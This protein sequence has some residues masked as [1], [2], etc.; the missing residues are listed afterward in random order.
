MMSHRNGEWLNTMS[1]E[2]HNGDPIKVRAKR[3]IKAGEQIYT[4]YNHC[5][6]CGN[7]LTSYGTPE[8]LRDYGFVEQFPQSWIFHGEDVAFRIDEVKTEAGEPTGEIQLVEWI[9]GDPDED[10]MDE[11]ADLLDELARNKEKYLSVRDPSVPDNE[12]SI[13]VQ[14]VDA[15][16]FAIS[17][18]IKTYKETHDFN[19]VEEGTC[20]VSADKYTDLEKKY[21]YE[22]VYWTGHECDIAAIFE[23]FDEEFE[24]LE[25]TDSQYQHI[26]WSWDPEV[27]PLRMKVVNLFGFIYYSDVLTAFVLLYSFINP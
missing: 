5:E 3:N 11:F 16:E 1:N 25:E 23:R 22:D 14:Y 6:D 18:A 4:T 27:R 15:M 10:D 26:I 20:I 12:W 24:D 8:I 2:V 7:R 13:I 19:C 9:E 21:G 17:L